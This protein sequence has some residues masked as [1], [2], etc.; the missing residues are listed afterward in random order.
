MDGDIVA[1]EHLSKR[2]KRL[3]VGDVVV[4]ISPVNPGRAVCKRILGMA[5]DHVCEDPTLADSERKFID[6][7]EGHVWLSGDNLSNSNDSRTYGPVPYGLIRG[8][9]F[10][11]V[12][13]DPGWIANNFL[14][15]NHY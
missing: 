13:P 15:Y 4:C 7:P 12:W 11:R 8:R 10:A 2:F 14:P 6:V 9:V 1:I 3:S 5:G